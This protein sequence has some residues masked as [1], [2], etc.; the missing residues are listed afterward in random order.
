MNSFE[1]PIHLISF[2]V[3]VTHIFIGACTILTNGQD[4]KHTLRQYNI[5]GNRYFRL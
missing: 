5:Y 2:N 1:F 4:K 3:C